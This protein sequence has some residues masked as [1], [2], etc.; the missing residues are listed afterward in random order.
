MLKSLFFMAIKSLT[1]FITYR[2]FSLSEKCKIKLTDSF[3]PLNIQV[4]ASYK[5]VTSR[6]LHIHMQMHN[7]L[8]NL[9]DHICR[10]SQKL[11]LYSLNRVLLEIDV[12]KL[13]M[14]LMIQ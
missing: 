5:C 6:A 4:V 12:A 1:S 2:V 14:L 13:S 8:S 11:K 10:S 7:M 9:L 3:V